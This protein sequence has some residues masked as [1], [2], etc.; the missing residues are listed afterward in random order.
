MFKSIA[1]GFNSTV[2]GFNQTINSMKEIVDNIALIFNTI[3]EILGFIGLKV[4]ILLFISYMVLWIFNLIN[5]INKKFNYFVSVAFALFVAFKNDMDKYNVIGKYLLII[6]SPFLII[7][8]IKYLSM[9]IK[10]LF[11][12]DYLKIN[13]L[14]TILKEK[15]VFYSNYLKIKT[16]VKKPKITLLCNKIKE[17]DILFL[18][19]SIADLNVT[20]ES[21]FALKNNGDEYILQETLLKNNFLEVLKS[22]FNIVYL[23]KNSINIDNLLYYLDELKTSKQFKLFVSNNYYTNLQLFLYQK[24]NWINYNAGF[25]ENFILNTT[26][27]IEH[28][29]KN[30]SINTNFKTIKSIVIGG[31]IEDILQNLGTRFSIKSK[32]KILILDI[33]NYYKK[34]GYLQ[35]FNYFK[36]NNCLPKSI[37]FLLDDGVK[38][39]EFNDIYKLF[40]DTKNIIFFNYFSSN[41][42]DYFLGL[43]SVIENDSTNNK[44]TFKQKIN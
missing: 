32:N 2:D 22:S 10:N 36:D 9:F 14:F 24:F 18:K 27:N 12:K 13:L 16:I 42:F 30:L 43:N 25:D 21:Y 5:P 33:N 38:N 23:Y 44:I 17:E 29:L 19:S 3:G 34:E 4:F 20:G 11:I 8:V 35:L 15:I 28:N 40:K 1:N 37:I 41:Y 7:S 26:L 31:K 6:I 39:E